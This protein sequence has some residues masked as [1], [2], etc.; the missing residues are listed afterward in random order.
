MRICQIQRPSEEPVVRCGSASEGRGL[1]DRRSDL[2]DLIDFSTI[3]GVHTV[4]S[5][6]CFLIGGID[7]NL[8]DSPSKILRFA[9]VDALV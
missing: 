3:G 1:F 2:P 8:K 9:G 6:I 7:C 5:T 4:S